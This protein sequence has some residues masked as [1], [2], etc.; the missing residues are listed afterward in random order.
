MG[1]AIV[2]KEDRYSPP[3]LPTMLENITSILAFLAQLGSKKTSAVTKLLIRHDA[4]VRHLH[5]VRC[6]ENL[7]LSSKERD[8]D[9]EQSSTYDHLYK[10]LQ[11]L[12]KE[13]LSTS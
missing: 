12:L 13:R 3:P 9:Q 5:C 1:I 6:K 7:T 2:L 4:V 11:R 10:H 8:H